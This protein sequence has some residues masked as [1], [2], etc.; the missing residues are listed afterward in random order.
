MAISNACNIRLVRWSDCVWRRNGQWSSYRSARF[1]I[2]SEAR[3]VLKE[4]AML[5]SP[6]SLRRYQVGARC[7]GSE[8]I[9]C[10]VYGRLPAMTES[11]LRQS[12][13][14]YEISFFFLFEVRHSNISYLTFLNMQWTPLGKPILSGFERNSK[15]MKTGWRMPHHDDE[16]SLMTWHAKYVL[17]STADQ[18]K[19]I[20]VITD[21]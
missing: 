6:T 13:W 17:L 9:S 18:V 8:K 3:E 15:I 14:E 10:R 2:C 1:Y 7:C 19:C 5:E 12:F 21:K 4:C 11:T 20:W 16:S